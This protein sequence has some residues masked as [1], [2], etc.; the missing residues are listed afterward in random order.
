MVRLL[1]YQVKNILQQEKIPIP[2]QFSPDDLDN[3]T[4][5]PIVIKS[6][7]PTGGRG[8]QGGIQFAET[9]AEAKKISAEL[10]NRTIGGY[11][12]KKLL[13]EERLATLKE[14]YCGFLINR[15]EKAI[16]FI[17][18]ETGGI[19]IEQISQTSQERL[20]IHQFI[21]FP[22]NLEELSKDLVRTIPLERLVKGQLQS[23]VTGLLRIIRSYDAELLEINPLI[24]TTEHKLIC[25]DIHMEIDDNA[26][27]RH[28]EYQKNL[29]YYL[30]PLELKAR[31][32]NMSYIELNGNIGVIC[33]GAGLVMGT[34]DA[35]HSFG[36]EAANFLDVGGG[37][38]VERMYHALKIISSNEKVQTIL[39][40]IIGGITRCDEIAKGLLKFLSEGTTIDFSLRLIGTNEKEGQEILKPYNITI[41]RELND[42]I[43]SI[44]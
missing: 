13:Y 35:I 34:I 6:Q 18:S 10:K 21:A 3:P 36:G 41:Y 28:P 16:N 12:P 39:I 1:E 17:F 31:S 32:L 7:V 27:F 40:N 5:Y 42:A 38:D 2:T 43:Q 26:L 24:E 11:R 15:D 20:H 25:A 33:N 29:E 19:D 4:I 44:L 23:L 37:A 30:T 9:P 8:K 14:Y 22:E